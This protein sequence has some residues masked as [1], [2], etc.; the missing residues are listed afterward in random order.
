MP[1][2]NTCNPTPGHLAPPY[3]TSPALTTPSPS[4]QAQPHSHPGAD[5][6]SPARATHI[7]PPQV[8]VNQNSP[9]FPE[10]GGLP[11]SPRP[12]YPLIMRGFAPQTPH[13]IPRIPKYRTPTR[14][15]PT[16]RQQ[17]CFRSDSHVRFSL[18]RD[19]RKRGAKHIK[20]VDEVR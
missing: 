11:P 8:I 5:D 4:S 1:L 6:P 20:M 18:K 13:R 2:G 12:P 7:T 14:T 9:A 16:D 15:E 17:P 3:L 19:H 10:G